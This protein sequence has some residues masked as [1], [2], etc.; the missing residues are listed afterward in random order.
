MK[1]NRKIVG[2]LAALAIIVSIVM[3]SVLAEKEGCA[4]VLIF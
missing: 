3:V 1:K 4:H 2:A